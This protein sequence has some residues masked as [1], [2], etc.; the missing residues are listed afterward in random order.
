MNFFQTRQF[1]HYYLIIKQKYFN[2]QAISYL[3]FF[4]KR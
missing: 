3:K 1:N 2:D 4:L